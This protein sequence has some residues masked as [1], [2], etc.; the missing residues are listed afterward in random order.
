[1]ISYTTI[2]VFTNIELFVN[3]LVSS[4]VRQMQTHRVITILNNILHYDK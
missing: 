3:I 2:L 4:S 1:M